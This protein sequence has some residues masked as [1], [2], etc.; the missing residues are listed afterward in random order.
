MNTCSVV[1][2]QI[3]MG[4]ASQ[5]PSH[6]TVHTQA[7]SELPPL[8]SAAEY[9][10]A[11]AQ[12][13]ILAAEDLTSDYSSEQPVA[14]EQPSSN[15]DSSTNSA[16]EMD[17][18]AEPSPSEQPFGQPFTDFLGSGDEYTD[19]D[20]EEPI[21]GYCRNCTNTL[22]DHYCSACGHSLQD[23]PALFDNTPGLEVED[24]VMSNP[25]Q[26]IALLWDQRMEDHEEGRP[27]PHPERPDRVRAV[28]A[29]LQAS[30]L[31]G[32]HPTAVQPSALSLSC[33]AQQPC[34]RACHWQP[35]SGLV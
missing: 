3:R 7:H 5:W 27:N 34:S 1:L 25:Q 8:L 19:G 30:G 4:P 17:T 10:P 9:P 11:P 33:M 12:T 13:T 14:S 2:A 16:R 28:M 23:D 18:G 32:R 6:M 21:V 31:T 22:F 20:L 29:R 26:P 15:L 35:Q 24:A